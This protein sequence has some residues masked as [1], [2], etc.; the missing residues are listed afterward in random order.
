MR[1]GP[2]QRGHRITLACLLAAGLTGCTSTLDFSVE[3]ERD[4]ACTSL[5]PEL[6]C[7]HGRCVD[8][9][10]LLDAGRPRDASLTDPDARVPGLPGLLGEGCM[11]LGPLEAERQPSRFLLVGALVPADPVEG[12]PARAAIELAVTEVNDAGGVHGRALAVLACSEPP[13]PEALADRARRMGE[14]VTVPALIGAS[15]PEGTAQVF[16]AAARPHGLVLLHPGGPEPSRATLGDDGLLWHLSAGAP[17]AAGA[18]AALVDHLG[19]GRVAI[20]HRADAWGEALATQ[21]AAELCPEGVCPAPVD[22]VAFAPYQPMEGVARSLAEMQAVWV[23]PI[24]QR[25]DFIGLY[26]A[27]ADQGITHT[28]AVEGPTEAEDLA[29][30]MALDATGQT[31]LPIWRADARRALLCGSGSV[32]ASTHGPAYG[33]W[34][35]RFAAAHPDVA[36]RPSTPLYADAVFTLAY[37]LVAA[38]DRE[39]T[40]GRLGTAIGRLT[41]GPVVEVGGPGWAMGSTQVESGGIDLEGVSGGLRFDVQTGVA[42]SAVD[43]IWYDDTP[44]GAPAGVVMDD[45]GRFSAPLPRSPCGEE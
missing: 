9:P 33:A 27:L 25:I 26:A 18:V 12:L 3:C 19:G 37:A 42:G 34:A 31:R 17:A 43:A 6:I 2:P 44:A 40:G 21:V 14:V 7:R 38:G 10:P 16:Q 24:A 5:G 4:E 29:A 23:I 1:L 32:N 41:E 36:L 20:V 39:V 8:P 35:M 11:V 30:F 13:T 15:T 22:Q 45:Q 28:L